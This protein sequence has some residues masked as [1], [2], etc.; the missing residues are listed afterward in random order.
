VPAETPED[1]S[2]SLP[3]ARLDEARRAAARERAVRTYLTRE[4][5]ELVRERDQLQRELE[6]LTD[7]LAELE[8]AA[9]RGPSEDGRADAE[10]ARLT[11]ALEDERGQR[12][13]TEAQLAR[14][15]QRRVV[16]ATGV[17]GRRDRSLRATLTLPV[18]V[19]R[20][21]AR[22]GET[23]A[24]TAPA[25]P[26][27]A[28][29]EGGSASPA[30]APPARAA[31]A[32]APPAPASRKPPS[33]SGPTRDRAEPAG[34]SPASLPHLPELP[35]VVVVPRRPDL[36]VAL[37]ADIFTAEAFRHEF[38][39]IELERTRWRE[40]LE[41]TP[42]DLLLVES[43]WRGRDGAWIHRFS[44]P[45]GPLEDAVELVAWCRERG[46]PT[47][48]WNKEDP[49]N[50][51]R[52][53]RSAALFDHVFTTD[54]GS[55]ERYRADL[56]HDRV[57]V[58]PFAAQ[59]RLHRPE[60][61]PGGRQHDV[62]FAGSYFPR[63]HP[64]R[65]E[66]MDL[67]LG[68][69]LDRDLHIYSRFAP[70]EGLVFP[71][72][73]DEHVVGTVPYEQMRAVYKRYRLFLNVNS[74]FR[75][76]T[77]CSRRV[78]ECLASGTPVVSTPAAAYEGLFGE[79]HPVVVCRDRDEADQQLDLLLRNPELRDR[80][81]VRGIR[82]VTDGH[83]YRHRADQLLTTVGL[84][85][86]PS[87]APLVSAVVATRRPEMLD[88]V[89]AN[90]SRQRVD[91]LELVLVAHG[92]EVDAAELRDRLPDL[93][94]VRVVSAGPELRLG[95]VTN[96][97]FLEAAGDVLTKMDD[98]DH[99]GANYLGDQL[100][101]LEYSEADIV[102]KQSLY[103]YVGS[104]DVTVLRFPGREHQFVSFV[105]GATTMMHRY[106]F[107]EVMFPDVPSGMDTRFFQAVEQV[108]LRVYATDRFNF[109]YIRGVE[110]EGHTW[111]RGDAR[112]LR[113]GRVVFAGFHPDHV[114]V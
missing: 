88:R 40:Q 87:R 72:P 25:R 67:L 18:D 76:P 21:L 60:R 82:A 84:L 23:T 20:E 111:R 80:L 45:D 95:T 50:Y 6:E 79:D 36:T 105:A 30:P 44:L 62:A 113:N 4:R 39:V 73:L 108:G 69:A 24:R 17:F 74:V 2:R 28:R 55:V 43:V 41:R 66:Q 109:L 13:A 107:D 48:F 63:K 33:T 92:F 14:L 71:P 35:P 11:R 102:G 65:R 38:T 27:P 64:E 106:V 68:A 100:R 49:P 61:L 34:A 7:R 103:A 32:P 78:F 9:A 114:E 75:S 112:I 70:E 19:A 37:V 101:A 98:D 58:L 52:F 5:D 93:E 26:S 12:A 57:H 110:G 16:R 10:V 89:V 94:D 22:P 86:S 51:D 42:P 91:R 15:K 96:L 53:V 47:A 90:L 54:A 59:M 77:T 31:S 56:G 29:T 104:S 83:T 3:A 85:T 97:G 8:S 81:A 46:I 1:P 99:Y